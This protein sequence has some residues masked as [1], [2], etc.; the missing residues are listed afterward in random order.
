MISNLI[1]DYNLRNLSNPISITIYMNAY[2]ISI[3]DL[4]LFFFHEGGVFTGETLIIIYIYKIHTY[5]ITTLLWYI[6]QMHCS[7][8]TLCIHIYLY[9][10]WKRFDFF[11]SLESGKLYYD[12]V[13]DC[14]EVIIDMLNEW[15]H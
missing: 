8:L 5:G 10:W 13:L 9:I 14:Y 6:N 4:L 11:D 12:G 2:H 3:F 1:F 15:T 7:Y